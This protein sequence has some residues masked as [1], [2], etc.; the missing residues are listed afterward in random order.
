MNTGKERPPFP[1]SDEE[2]IEEAL[3]TVTGYANRH[4]GDDFNINDCV[5]LTLASVKDIWKKVRHCATYQKLN[6]EDLDEIAQLVC[7]IRTDLSARACKKAS[8]CLKNRK[9]QQINK[10]T[11]EALI[12]YELRQRGLNYFFEW[13][14]LRVKVSIKLECKNVITVIIK[15]K[16]I[17]EGKLTEILDKVLAIADLHNKAGVPLTVWSLTGRWRNWNGWKG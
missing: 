6:W 8:E 13:Q 9:I 1:L 7:R 11:A 2:V 5:E 16:D 3:K 14:K 10:M 15:Y 12:V 4:P 17:R